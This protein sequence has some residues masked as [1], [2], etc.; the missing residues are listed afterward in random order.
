MILNVVYM[1][2]KVK[3]NVQTAHVNFSEHSITVGARIAQL[4]K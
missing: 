1:K 3:Q 4:I 2:I